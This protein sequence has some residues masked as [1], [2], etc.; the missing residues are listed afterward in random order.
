MGKIQRKYMDPKNK[1]RHQKFGNHLLPIACPYLN[2]ISHK[3]LMAIQRI[4]GKQ[5]DI[6][7]IA[8]PQKKCYWF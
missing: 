7:V 3:M 2:I 5:T 4:K 1:S 8:V 6:L